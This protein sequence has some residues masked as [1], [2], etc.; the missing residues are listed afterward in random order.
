MRLNIGTAQSGCDL[1]AGNRSRRGQFRVYR[2]H[3]TAG[4]TR[5]RYPRD[6]MRQISLGGA[7]CSVSHTATNNNCLLRY[8]RVFA[9]FTV[10]VGSRNSLL[11]ILKHRRPTFVIL[12]A[13]LSGKTLFLKFH[14]SFIQTRPL[15]GCHCYPIIV[16]TYFRLWP[17]S[18][19]NST[20]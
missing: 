1:P 11:D 18:A 13:K 5:L 2:S 4:G 9:S 16:M 8:L 3:M 17:W 15:S 14:F 7:A 19:C 6:R 12:I 20:F 10:I